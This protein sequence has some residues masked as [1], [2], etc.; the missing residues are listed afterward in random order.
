[1]ARPYEAKTLRGIPEDSVLRACSRVEGR[2]RELRELLARGAV[3][4]QRI[5]SGLGDL[6]AAVEEVG[7]PAG[8]SK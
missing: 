1:L 4:R 2:S 3:E 6:R 8:R 5:V 7:R